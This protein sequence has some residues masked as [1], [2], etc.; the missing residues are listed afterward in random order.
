MRSRAELERVQALLEGIGN[1]DIPL[2]DGY[3]DRCCLRFSLILGYA[4]D[5]DPAHPFAEWIDELVAAAA[6][7]RNAGV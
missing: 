1:G 3:C 2:P 7:Q 5:P 6:Y 4:L